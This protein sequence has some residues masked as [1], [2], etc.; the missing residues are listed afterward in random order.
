[1]KNMIIKIFIVIIVLLLCFVGIKKLNN[2]NLFDRNEKIY[3]ENTN[4]NHVQNGEIENNTNNTNRTN[5][6]IRF[7]DSICLAI[8]YVHPD[9]VEKFIENTF[10]DIKKYESLPI[11][12]LGTSNKFVIIPKEKGGTIKVWTCKMDDNYQ[13]VK[14]EMVASQPNT[15]GIV[16]ETGEIEYI[17]TVMIEYV[18]P[19][20]FECLVPLTFS[21]KDG[22]LNLTGYEADVMDISIY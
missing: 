1:M 19:S 3:K 4:D 2:N 5:N 12:K 11:I 16:V 18:D 8:G 6:K 14:D 13:M 9:K 22:S 10:E 17:P 7:T 20:S 15:S 21:G